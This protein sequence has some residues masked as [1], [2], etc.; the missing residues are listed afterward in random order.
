MYP[1]LLSGLFHCKTGTIILSKLLCITKE[2]TRFVPQH[3]ATIIELLNLLFKVKLSVD[4]AFK[5]SFFPNLEQ[6][7]KSNPLS[8]Q[9]RPKGLGRNWKTK[10]RRPKSFKIVPFSRGDHHSQLVSIVTTKTLPNVF[11]YCRKW[12]F[13]CGLPIFII[14]RV[15]MVRK[16]TQ[17]NVIKIYLD[18][19]CWKGGAAPASYGHGKEKKH[20]ISKLLHTSGM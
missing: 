17:I 7:F 4:C 14:L 8:Y 2:T 20:I 18:N 6:S 11:Q 15:F 10:K 3:Q 1:V 5:H 16:L 13:P 9:N 19:F 12:Q